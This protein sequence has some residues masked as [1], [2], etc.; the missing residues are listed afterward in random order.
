MHIF[1]S[2]PGLSAVIYFLLLST[3]LLMFKGSLY[4][5]VHKFGLPLSL[6]LPGCFLLSS[7]DDDDS[8]DDD[9]DDSFLCFRC[10]LCFLCLCFFLFALCLDDDDTSLLLRFC[11]FLVT[12]RRL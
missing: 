1:D 3:F 5:D 6:S 7:S 12:S 10:F 8:E 9:D 4:E 2:P 11:G